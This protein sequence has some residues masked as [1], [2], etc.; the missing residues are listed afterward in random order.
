[1]AFLT[2]YNEEYVRQILLGDSREEGREEGWAAGTAVEEY[3]KAKEIIGRLADEKGW[4]FGE[5][6]ISP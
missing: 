1:M 6:A 5:N 3:R 4:Q 2:R